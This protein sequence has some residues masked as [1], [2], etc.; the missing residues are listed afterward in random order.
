MQITELLKRIHEGDAEAL[1][2]VIPLLYNELRKLAAACGGKA[3]LPIHGVSVGYR[4]A[5]TGTVAPLGAQASGSFLRAPA[6]RSKTHQLVPAFEELAPEL[7]N[8]FFVPRRS[9]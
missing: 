3:K 2:A 7:A 4:N 8:F 5:P 1:S 6:N 9:K